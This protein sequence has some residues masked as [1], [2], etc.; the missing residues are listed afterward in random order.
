MKKLLILL[1]FI[2]SCTS[3]NDVDISK[4]PIITTV[5]ELSKSYDVSLDLSG[6]Y[7]K[8]TITKYIDGSYELEYTYDLLETDEF[9]PL[10]YSIT[11]TKERTVKDAI[12]S[13][14]L[15]KGAVNLVSNSFS[16]GTIKVDTLEL[17]GD[18]SYYAIRTYNGEQNGVLFT[19]R[20]G[21]FIYDLIT[22]GIYT[23][24]HSL[25]V[26]LII[27]DIENL[28]DFKLKTRAKTGHN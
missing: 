14:H 9:D 20:K 4:Y 26:D 3:D 25:I 18:E 17:P 23:D 11:I 21:R 27:P 13:Y 28:V 24:D 10:F 16:Q 1:I 2:I 5:T 7:E 22:S 12:E 6:N 8:S 15:T 19:I